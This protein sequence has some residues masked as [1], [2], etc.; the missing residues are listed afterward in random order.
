MHLT[1]CACAYP[2]IKLRRQLTTAGPSGVTG[3]IKFDIASSSYLALTARWN[4][5]GI[6]A[7]DENGSSWA[8]GSVHTAA[9]AGPS[10]APPLY[11]TRMPSDGILVVYRFDSESGLWMASSEVMFRFTGVQRS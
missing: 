10:S 11:T 7:G 6:N 2:R 5:S 3:V 9:A 8:G 4:G 1:A